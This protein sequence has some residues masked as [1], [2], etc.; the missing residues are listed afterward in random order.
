MHTSD[1]STQDSKARKLQVQGQPGLEKNGG[2]E[3]EKEGLI[4]S[5]LDTE[6]AEGCGVLRNNGFHSLT[7]IP[8]SFPQEIKLSRQ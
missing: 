6:K 2:R 5:C 4:C 8:P 1:P 3:R 7:P